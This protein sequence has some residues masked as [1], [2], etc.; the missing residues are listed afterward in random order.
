MKG[1]PAPSNLPYGL[2]GLSDEAVELL[3]LDLLLYT[4]IDKDKLTHFCHRGHVPPADPEC[5][6]PAH[7]RPYNRVCGSPRP[8][9]RGCVP[10]FVQP[11]LM[12]GVPKLSPAYCVLNC[13][14]PGCAQTLLRGPLGRGWRSRSDERGL[15]TAV[16]GVL[17]AVGLRHA[18]DARHRLPVGAAP[19]KLQR[20]ETVQPAVRVQWGPVG[21]LNQR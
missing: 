14:L 21:L 13:C 4:V 1:T 19:G 11:H 16:V 10:S 15:Q 2:F 6:F 5:I 20:A 8:Q 3:G 7:H 9:P 17:G 12:G 18:V